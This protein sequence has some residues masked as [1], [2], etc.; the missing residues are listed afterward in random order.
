[1]AHV[2]ENMGALLHTRDL[3]N[4]P[5]PIADE[6]DESAGDLVCYSMKSH[7]PM[8]VKDRVTTL[9]DWVGGM[10]NLRG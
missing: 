4:T 7:T 2:V 10:I 1:M 8:S 3:P 9:P 6:D 5:V